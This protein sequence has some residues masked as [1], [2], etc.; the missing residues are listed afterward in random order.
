MRMPTRD[1]W[2]EGTT[3]DCAMI[4]SGSPTL[5]PRMTGQLWVHA[6]RC[7]PSLSLFS[8]NIRVSQHNHRIGTPAHVQKS[9]LR[10]HRSAVSAS[11]PEHFI[12]MLRPD[13]NAWFHC[14]P[15]SLPHR[16]KA[17]LESPS[18]GALRLQGAALGQVRSGPY[19]SFAGRAASASRRLLREAPFCAGNGASRKPGRFRSHTRFRGP[20]DKPKGPARGLCA[21][22]PGAAS[23]EDTMQRGGPVRRCANPHIH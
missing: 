16:G 18:N 20:V 17:G 6:R 11:P 8:A 13:R 21:P 10:A 15:I 7:E 14:C 12:V 5:A 2:A 1:R 4:K 19:V 9:M 3:S 23:S 22:C